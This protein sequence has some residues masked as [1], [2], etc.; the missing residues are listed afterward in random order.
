M[1]LADRIVS[2]LGGLTVTAGDRAGQAFDVLPWERRLIRGAWNTDDDVPFSIARG[3]GKTALVAGIACA[4]VDPDGPL[5][6]PR[7]ETVVVASS[8]TQGKICFEDVVAMLAAKFDLDDRKV[9][10]VQDSQNIASVEHRPTGARVRCIGS[11]PARA[12]GLRP[13]LAL[14]DEPAQ[15][16]RSKSDGML[17]AIRTALG[18]VPGS[19]MMA[20][21][22]RPADST[23]WFNKMLRDASFSLMYAARP[24][25]NPLLMATVTAGESLVRP[26]AEPQG[27]DS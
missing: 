23:H 24:S 1:S 20:L 2:Y 26:S 7:G 5:S 10:R 4:A 16:S 8:F 12:H 21:G 6:Y 22:T 19:K 11:D 27:Q 25:D 9:W 15:W 18:K 14:L 3:N 17:A 13:M